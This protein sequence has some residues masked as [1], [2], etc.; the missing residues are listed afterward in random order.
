MEAE[1]LKIDSLTSPNNV[2]EV[3]PRMAR[4]ALLRGPRELETVYRCLELLGDVRGIFKGCRRILIKVNFISVKRYDTGVTTDPLVVE[5]LI[6]RLREDAEVYVVESDA[7]TTNAY[8]AYEATGM[9]RICEENGV[10][11]INLRWEKD[12]VTLPVPGG[13]VLKEI[14]VPKIVVESAIV[15][16]GKLKTHSETVVTLGMKNLF[17]LLPDKWKFKYHMRDINKVVVDV[18]AVLRPRLTIIDGFYGLEGPGPSR[19]TPVKMDLLIAGVDPV[20]TDATACRVMGVDPLE[21][22]HIRRAYER[23]IGEVNANRI[24]VVGNSVE[25][26]R[27][28]FRRG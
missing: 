13:E 19:G 26:V 2:H 4:V 1:E 12:R 25:E 8:E 27:R 15:S 5:G 16:A 10:S 18:A 22:P 28:V 24:E 6:R 23:G 21:V 7:T 14:T 3:Q 9:R 20:A 11:F 17:G